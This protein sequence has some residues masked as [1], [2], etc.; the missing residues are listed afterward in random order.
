MRKRILELELEQARSAQKSAIG[1]ASPSGHQSGERSFGSGVEWGVRE[2]EAGGLESV[3]W[4]ELPCG[5]SPLYY[6]GEA[7]SAS[8]TRS[9]A[10]H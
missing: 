2:E 9:M 1:H 3:K 5:C 10:F 6:L 8:S 4:S 7:F